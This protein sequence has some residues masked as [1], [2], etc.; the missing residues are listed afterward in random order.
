MGVPSLRYICGSIQ[1]TLVSAAA[2]AAAAGAAA[3]LRGAAAGEHGPLPPSAG[4]KTT[5]NLIYKEFMLT[6]YMNELN[7]I[8]FSQLSR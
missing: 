2:A 7:F 4:L 1:V 3:L 6:D 8:T 5:A